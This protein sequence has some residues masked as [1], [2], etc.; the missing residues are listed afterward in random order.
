MRLNRNDNMFQAITKVA[1][2]NPGAI[3]AI[4]TIAE[5]SPKVDPKH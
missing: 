5:V 2:G 1:E 4:M 3:V